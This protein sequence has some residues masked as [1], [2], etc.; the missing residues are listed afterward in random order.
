M[1]RNG[2]NLGTSPREL[3]LGERKVSRMNFSDVVTL[4][5]TFTKNCLSGNKMVKMTMNPDGS[6]TLRPIKSE[7]KKDGC[8][9]G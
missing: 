7:D 8:S 5:K 3:E 4:P 6:L 9:D 2:V 1:N